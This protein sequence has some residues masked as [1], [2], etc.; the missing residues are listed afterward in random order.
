MFLKLDSRYLAFF[1]K[2]QDNIEISIK[3]ACVSRLSF[4]SC[5]V[6]DWDSMGCVVT[7]TRDKA[8]QTLARAFDFLLSLQKLG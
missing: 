8:F 2:F 4:V 3:M 6:A 7:Q 1:S 5:T